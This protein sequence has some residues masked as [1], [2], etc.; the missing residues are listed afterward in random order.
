MGTCRIESEVEEAQRSASSHSS[1]S[2]HF[3]DRKPRPR[4]GKTLVPSHTAEMIKF[5][6]L[7]VMW[8]RLFKKIQIRSS[9]CGSV[10]MNPTSLH[11]DAGSIPGFT[12]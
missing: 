4:E 12:Q 6:F 10:V 7:L 2:A 11:E 8:F 5:T 9:C 3:R 1:H